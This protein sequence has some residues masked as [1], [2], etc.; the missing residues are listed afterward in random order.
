LP[1]I[2]K[3]SMYIYEYMIVPNM[4]EILVGAFFL[5]A[6]KVGSSLLTGKVANYQ[7]II[8]ED[9]NLYRWVVY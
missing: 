8:V 6:I 4:L 5:I 3:V 2:E 9:H 7:I 1:N